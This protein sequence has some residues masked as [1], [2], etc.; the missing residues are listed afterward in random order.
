VTEEEITDIFK[1]WYKQDFGLDTHN[2]V[3]MHFIQ[4]G[5]ESNL[6]GSDL[7]EFVRHN[8]KEMLGMHHILEYLTNVGLV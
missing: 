3:M 4:K 2:Q 1:V 8:G 5:I 6:H 7:V